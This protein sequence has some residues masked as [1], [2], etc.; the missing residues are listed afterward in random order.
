MLVLLDVQPGQKV[1]DVGSGSGWTTALLGEL[2]GPTGSVH[3]VE[4][5]S[6]LVE[7]GATNLKA[8]AMP[9]TSIA[10]ADRWVLGLPDEAPFDRILVSAEA[11][12]IPSSL[13]DQLVV[14]GVLVVPVNGR[15]TVVRRT[16]TDPLVTREGHYAFVPLIEPC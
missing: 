9:W 10:Q 4:I 12:R 7:W 3:G 15:M 11:T 14:G 13:V 2:V 5:V 1:L 6:E 16:E 8:Y